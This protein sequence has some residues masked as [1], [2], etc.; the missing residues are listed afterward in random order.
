M[1]RSEAEKVSMKCAQAGDFSIFAAVTFNSLS[2]KN[3]LRFGNLV[4]PRNAAA[5][6]SVCE[7]SCRN[8]AQKL[9]GKFN[10]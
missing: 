2:Q 8:D 7:I 9:G 3:M 4:R 10:A 6:V 1:S 5:E